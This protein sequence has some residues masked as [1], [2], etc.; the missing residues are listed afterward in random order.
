MRA[1]VVAPGEDVARGAGETLRPPD[2]SGVEDDVLFW[3]GINRGGPVSGSAASTPD[4]AFS[5]DLEAWLFR[6]C[7][8]MFPSDE[9]RD[10]ITLFHAGALKDPVV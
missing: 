5:H 1:G 7:A 8:M 4:G 2:G 6:R 10:G 3:P 9:A